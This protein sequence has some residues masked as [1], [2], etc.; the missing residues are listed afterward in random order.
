[1]YSQPRAGYMLSKIK[2]FFAA[3]GWIYACQSLSYAF[4]AELHA[5]VEDSL[6]LQL[7]S[8]L[9]RWVQLH[10]KVEDSPWLQLSSSLRR[11]VQLHGKVEDSPWLQPSLRRWV[12]LHA[13]VEDSPWCCS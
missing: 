4:A 10:G 3:S 13:K 8:S 11:W 7:S 6:W 1:M 9:R 12:Q 5:K 2:H